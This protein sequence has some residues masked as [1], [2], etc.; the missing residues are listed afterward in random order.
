[1]NE[2]FDEVDLRSRRRT[3]CAEGLM[4][5][6]SRLMAVVYDRQIDEFTLHDET[7]F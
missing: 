6:S 2:N 3:G 7:R 4:S 5:M 1:M